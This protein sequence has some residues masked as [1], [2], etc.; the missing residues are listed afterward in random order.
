MNKLK[1]IGLT[2]LATSLVASSGYAA[3]VT[4]AGAAGFTWSTQAGATGTPDT[5]HGKGIGVDNSMTFNMSG[6]L[7]NGWSVAAHTAM[8]DAHALTTSAVALTLGDMGKITSGSGYGGNS[9]SYDE[10]TPRAY[11]Q[12]DDGAGGIASSMNKVGSANDN[13]GLNYTSPSIDLAGAS[14]TIHAGY[15]PKAEDAH[16][17]GG[18]TT[19]LST[20][21][22]GQDLGITISHDSGLKL[23][24]Y[25]AERT[26]EQNGAGLQ[27]AFEGTWYATYSMGPVSVGYQESYTDSGTSP[28]QVNA[29]ATA[30][31]D[32]SSG[33]FEANQIAIAFN[34][35]DDLSVSYQKLE[36]TYDAQ[37]GAAGGATTGGAAVADVTVDMKSISAAYS[38]GSMSIKA[39]RTTTDNIGYSN[40]AGSL[41]VNEIALGLSF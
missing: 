19:G 25:G 2:A 37:A 29:D 33:Y 31:W 32:T 15:V 10:E 18:V 6:E 36:D 17:A 9:A 35:N 3:E 5:D 23:G 27:D 4:I 38:M 11:E 12:V 13:G 34:V 16:S 26:R 7:D 39:Y 30:T 24:I 41:T 40:G 28:S 21:G 14:M 20:M 1:K 8:T 22:S